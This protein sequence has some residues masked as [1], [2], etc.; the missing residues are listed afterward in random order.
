[1]P[2][3]AKLGSSLARDRIDGASSLSRAALVT[4][5][6]IFIVALATYVR[7]L[8][9]TVTLVDSGELIVAA[10]HLGVAHPPGTPLYVLLAHLATLVPIGNVAVRVNFSSAL[11]AALAAA[12]LTLLLSQLLCVEQAEPSNA[13]SKSGKKRRKA[14][15]SN[16]AGQVERAGALAITPL[17]VSGLLLAFS[18]TLWSFA[19]I[20]E[21]YTLNTLL[22]LLIFFFLFRSRGS[23]SANVNQSRLSLAARRDHL[24][25]IAAFIFGLALGVH[26]VTVGVTLPAMAVLVYRTEGFRFF[27]SKR[28]LYAALISFSGLLLVYAYLP[29]AASRSPIMNWGDPRTLQRIWWHVS[30]RQYQV[31]LSFSLEQ[32]LG[33]ATAFGKLAANEFGPWW[34]P[35]AFVLATLGFI[36]A[37]N[38]DRTI[39]YFLLLLIAADLA[40]ALNY[41]IAEDKG[42][43]YLPAFIAV[44]IAAGLGARWMLLLATNKR[45]LALGIIAVLSAPVC[46]LAG[47]FAVSDRHRYFLARDYIDNI[48]S[49]IAPNGLLLTSDWQVYSPL[50]YTREIEGQRRD[51]IA[52]DVNLLR[53]SWYFAYLE[54]EY[55]GLM[56]QT[57]EQVESFL[58]DLKAWEQDPKAFDR[59][60]ELTQR[61]DSHFH[62]MLQAFI[63]AHMKTAPVYVTSELPLEN[64]SVDPELA[65]AINK[66]YQIFPQ[67]L[68]FQLSTERT[69]QSPAEPAF[70]TRGLADG[71]LAFEPD[72]VVL[73]K[74]KPVYLNMLV[75]RGLYLAA[76]GQQDRA[77]VAFRQALALDPSFA[78]AQKALATSLKAHD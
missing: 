65:H 39:F 21:V 30:G 48:E 63:S 59:S 44:T 43:Y 46:A 51:I 73:I 3:T 33:Q 76:H 40:Y 64:S 50:L 2:T 14:G 67:G 35:L 56:A 29:L 34:L 27:K 19:T 45:T 6:L 61:I 75:N 23:S 66:S 49:T 9:P 36:D 47:N 53:R 15:A 17:I 12:M 41:E 11:F 4:A 13:K 8:A 70:E 60:S 20:A 55:P 52:I 16:D 10:K 37:F 69:L 58:G 26:H 28:L 62:E 57:R 71:T 68:V 18:R 31:F 54:K 24:L 38:R 74:V 32:M 7:T 77:S 78:P 5:G 1:M 25:Y 22:I 42:A 72:D